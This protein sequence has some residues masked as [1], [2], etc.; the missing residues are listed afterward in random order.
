MYWGPPC[1]SE[2]LV[3]S[4]VVKSKENAYGCDE[5]VFKS[6]KTC[7][8]PSRKCAARAYEV[9]VSRYGGWLSR[10]EGCWNGLRAPSS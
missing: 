9:C 3:K 1:S 2:F 5:L 10:P 4:R 8:K 7:E 6:K